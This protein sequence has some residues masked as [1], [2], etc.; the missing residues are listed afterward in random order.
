MRPCH[1]QI[2]CSLLSLQLINAFLHHRPVI[3]DLANTADLIAIRPHATVAARQEQNVVWERPT[4]LK[5]DCVWK[6]HSAFAC[7]ALGTWRE[8]EF[9]F[10]KCD[11]TPQRGGMMNE[12]EG[13]RYCLPTQDSVKFCTQWPEDECQVPTEIIV[14]LEPGDTWP[15]YDRAI[16]HDPEWDAAKEQDALENSQPVRAVA[17]RVDGSFIFTKLKLTRKRRRDG[18]DESIIGEDICKVYTQGKRP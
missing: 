11:I 6:N 17:V 1:Y 10:K 14:S 15:P 18:Q 12:C 4:D 16:R 5:W 2:I 7:E 8:T 3:I 9:A 13:Y